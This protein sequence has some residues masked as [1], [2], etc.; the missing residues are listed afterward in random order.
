MLPRLPSC[1]PRVAPDFQGTRRHFVATLLLALG[2]PVIAFRV[3]DRIST[4]E[5][6]EANEESDGLCVAYGVHGGNCVMKRLLRH[7]PSAQK[8][9]VRRLLSWHYPRAR[10]P[11]MYVFWRRLCKTPRATSKHLYPCST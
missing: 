2:S 3:L 6:K 1:L 10:G 8:V 4:R 5:Q 7:L 9:E 11:C